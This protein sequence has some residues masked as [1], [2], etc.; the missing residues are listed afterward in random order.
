VI[1]VVVAVVIGGTLGGLWWIVFSE[2]VK[3]P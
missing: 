3:R 2:A 1:D